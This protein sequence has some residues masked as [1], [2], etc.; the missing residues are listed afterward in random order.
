MAQPRYETQQDRDNEAAMIQRAFSRI[1]PVATKLPPQYAVD[2]LLEYV[3]DD[4][5]RRAWVECKERSFKMAGFTTY[6]MSLHK[7]MKGMQLASWSGYP[8]ILLVQWTDALGMI[9]LN[10]HDPMPIEIGGRTDRGDPLDVEPVVMIPTHKF[11]VVAHTTP[12]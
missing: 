6:M 1:N 9:L 7:Y 3:K 10:E 8:F 5:K 11:K 4:Q 12:G 2:W